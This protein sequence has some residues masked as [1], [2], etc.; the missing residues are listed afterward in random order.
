MLRKMLAFGKYVEKDYC[1]GFCKQ[2]ADN[3]FAQVWGER[4]W[5]SFNLRGIT[6]GRINAHRPN[7]SK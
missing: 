5:E 2:Y 4:V 7:T 3:R 1:C 6:T